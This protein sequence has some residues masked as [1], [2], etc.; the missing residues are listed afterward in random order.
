MIWVTAGIF[1]LSCSEFNEWF[2]FSVLP[3]STVCAVDF[4][5]LFFVYWRKFVVLSWIF[6]F[7]QILFPICRG[8]PW[9]PFFNLSVWCSVLMDFRWGTHLALL[10]PKSCFACFFF[11]FYYIVDFI[12]EFTYDHRE[13]CLYFSSFLFVCAHVLSCFLCWGWLP[14]VNCEVFWNSVKIPLLNV[15][16]ILVCKAFGSGASLSYFSFYRYCPTF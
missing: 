11:F 2:F 13:V 16:G 5:S 7:Y 10:D 12:S 1:V 6:N 8:D 9:G 15:G 14:S 4:W 3:L